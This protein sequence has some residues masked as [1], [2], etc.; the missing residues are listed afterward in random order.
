MHQQIL[1]N[2]RWM[3]MIV[4]AVM[5]R[6]INRISSKGKGTSSLS[7]Q[8]VL[9][10]WQ[11]SPKISLK[12]GL[13]YSNIAIGIQPQTLYATVDNNQTISYKFITSSGYAYVKAGVWG[14]TCGW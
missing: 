14:I 2:T 12:T 5:T 10:R 11:F 1:H 13:V 3:M 9:A 8:G 7:L 6:K 4:I